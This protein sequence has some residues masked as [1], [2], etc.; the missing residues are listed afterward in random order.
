MDISLYSYV[1]GPIGTNVYFLVYGKGVIIVD[2]AADFDRL[3]KFIDD[4]GLFPSAILITHG[5][6]DHGGAAGELREKYG[7]NVY[8]P[9]RD[10]VLFHIPSQNGSEM[11]P[12]TNYILDPDVYL[13]EDEVLTFGGVTLMILSTPGHT[14]GSMSYYFNFGDEYSFANPPGNGNYSGL[15]FSGDEIFAGS[16]G[17]TDMPTGSEEALRESVESIFKKLPDDTL[18]LP[19]HG[20]LTTIG[21]EKERNP[22][23]K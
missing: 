13:K 15:I 18:L 1:C 9:L 12:G 5:H 19:G 22:W 20:Q 2:P 10:R 3:S 6:F 8:A 7:V 14:A 23:F 16:V 11:V 4:N 21:T 17:R